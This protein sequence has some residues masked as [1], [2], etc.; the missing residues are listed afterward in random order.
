[1]IIDEKCP[2]CGATPTTTGRFFGQRPMGSCPQ[3]CASDHEGAANWIYAANRS[4]RMHRV[5]PGVGA[6][7]AAELPH[8]IGDAK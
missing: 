6:A 3:A 4:A 5:R 2:A 8:L 7:D 1:M